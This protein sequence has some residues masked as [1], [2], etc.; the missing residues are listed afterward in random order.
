MPSPGISLGICL[1]MCETI[2]LYIGNNLYGLLRHR[3]FSIE[4]PIPLNIDD[5]QCMR[6]LYQDWNTKILYFKKHI[7][8]DY[9]LLIWEEEVED[10]KEIKPELLPDVA[11]KNVFDPD[12]LADF[13][14]IKSEPFDHQEPSNVIGQIIAQP[15]KIAKDIKHELLDNT[16]KSIAEKQQNL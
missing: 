9:E 7:N 12:Y 8:S 10:I 14:P 6:P 15:P 13:L 16:T 2:L 11:I 1:E 3:P 5:I 4:W